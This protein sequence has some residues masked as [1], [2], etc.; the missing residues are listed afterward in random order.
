MRTLL[1]DGDVNRRA[2]PSSVHNQLMQRRFL[3]STRRSVDMVFTGKTQIGEFSL[4]WRR[5]YNVI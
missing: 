3:V 5:N 2:V 1:I 4:N